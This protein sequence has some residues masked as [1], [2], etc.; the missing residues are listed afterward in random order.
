MHS[1]FETIDSGC[2]EQD[3]RQCMQCMDGFVS[4]SVGG[5]ASALACKN[6]CIAARKERGLVTVDTFPKIVVGS[7]VNNVTGSLTKI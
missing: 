5:A 3:A 1:S 7:G 6:W 4:S 2:I